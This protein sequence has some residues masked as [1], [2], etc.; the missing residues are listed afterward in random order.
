M[1]QLTET[2]TEQMLDE[3]FISPEFDVPENHKFTLTPKE[4][5]ERIGRAAWEYR[6]AVVKLRQ[7]ETTKTIQ[8]KQTKIKLMSRS[9]HLL[10]NERL[11]VHLAL[12]FADPKFKWTEA[13]LH[14]AIFVELHELMN[15]YNWYEQAAKQ[16]IK[17]YE[18]WN[19][20]LMWYMSDN[21]KK[22]LEGIDQQT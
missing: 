3:E 12:I 7:L 1:K 22:R 18:M 8:E 13:G 20:M 21:K 19:S 14:D 6:S 2:M 5:Q 17:E 10:K 15:E 9:L 11:R 16:A 4:L